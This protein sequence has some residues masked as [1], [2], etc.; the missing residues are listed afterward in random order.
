MNID[1]FELIS[2]A[3]QGEIFNDFATG[4]IRFELAAFAT[5]LL[6]A[7]VTE[8]F[9]MDPSGSYSRVEMSSNVLTLDRELAQNEI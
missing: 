2:R 4:A 1:A 7:P 6:R 8:A 3:E 9:L 5:R